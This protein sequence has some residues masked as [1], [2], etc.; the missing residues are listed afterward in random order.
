MILVRQLLFPKPP[1]LK[2]NEE[3]FW[4][5]RVGEPGSYHSLP[6]FAA[7]EVTP[8]KKNRTMKNDVLKNDFKTG[9]SLLLRYKAFDKNIDELFDLDGLA[10]FYALTDFANTDH[11]L[12][13]HNLRFFVNFLA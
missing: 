9:Q 6:Y 7:A 1:L 5:T 11:A 12:I 4:E 2:F 13:W 3:G 10:R 8:F